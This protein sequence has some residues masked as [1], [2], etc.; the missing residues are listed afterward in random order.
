MQLRHLLLLWDRS[1]P[2]CSANHF[3]KGKDKKLKPQKK[4]VWSILKLNHSSN[5]NHRGGMY[6]AM[7]PAAAAAA[8]AAARHPVSPAL[9]VKT[10]PFF[11]DFIYLKKKVFFLLYCWEREK[12]NVCFGNRRVCR[13]G[14]R[15]V[16]CVGVHEIP[17][18]AGWT[19]WPC[20][21]IKQK[22]RS[23]WGF[24]SFFFQKWHVIGRNWTCVSRFFLCCRVHPNPVSLSSLPSTSRATGSKKNFH[25]SRLNITSEFVIMPPFLFIGN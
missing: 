13:L 1:R 8:A 4:L 16:Q 18:K 12:R 7:N 22:T 5:S 21:L 25:S 15:N 3:C 17:L 6:S 23:R 20:N 24:T 11:N 10:I 9:P 2:V 19:R 14:V